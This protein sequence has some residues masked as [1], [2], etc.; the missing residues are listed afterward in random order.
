MAEQPDF[1]AL[2]RQYLDLWEDQLTLMAADPDL[3]EQSARFFDAMTQ[4]GKDVNPMLSANLA[5]FLQQTQT[6]KA[7]ETDPTTSGTDRAK[8]PAAASDDRDKRMDQLT[9]RLDAV[10]KRL[11]QLEAGSPKTRGRSQSRAGKKPT[12]DKPTKA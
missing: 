7:N 3:A 10:E 6:G 5:E 8:T 9:R 1:A 4:L 2:A 12:K 11:E